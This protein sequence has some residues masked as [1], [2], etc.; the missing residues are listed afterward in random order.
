MRLML[1]EDNKDLAGF[2]AK[3]LRAAGFIVDSMKTGADA[4]EALATTA[5]DALVLDLG[6]PDM[7]GMALLKEIRSS[8][9]ETPILV[10]TARDGL[11]DRVRGL[12]AGADDYVLKP[13]MIEELSARLR[14]LLRR[15]VQTQKEAFGL[16]NV[17][18]RASSRE[19]EIASES[20]VLPRRE[21]SLLEELLRRPAH[22]IPRAFLEE[23]IY[24]FDDNVSPNSLEIV[25]SRLR[26][27]L[28]ESGADI[29]I[30]TFRGL[31]YML[32]KI[33]E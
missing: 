23:R 33:E 13:V 30:M 4:Q 32:R 14:A 12:D 24:G 5:Y 21:R 8:R 7:D 28:R 18:L 2:L 16:G 10:L 20:L 22:V 11:G 1:I 17:S 3:G 31:G 25:V 29:E 15:P 9:N 19:V 27:V 6:L 26:K